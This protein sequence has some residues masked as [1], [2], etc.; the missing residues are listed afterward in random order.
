MHWVDGWPEIG[1]DIDRNGIGEPVARHR[2]P[3]V[4][5]TYPVEVP[6][7]NDEFTSSTLG[8]QWQWEAN[9][10]SA[11]F[12]LDVRKGWLRLYTQAPVGYQN[13]LWND[14]N[15]LGQKIPGPEF[16]VTTRFEY[17]SLSNGEEAGLI[18]LGTDYAFIAIRRIE[19]SFKVIQNVC[20]D[21]DKGKSEQENS[22]VELTKGTIY[23]R[24]ELRRESLCRFSFSADGKQFQ[25]LGNEF[26][27][28]SGKW[29]GAKIGLF[30]SGR[31]DA[32]SVGFVD[33]DWIRFDRLR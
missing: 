8:L 32:R 2:K 14:G 5:R 31:D 13:N 7:T 3:D 24:L 4:V 28:K 1:A 12:S 26:H 15:I 23:L 18:V 19:D 25:Q 20:T 30:A 6:Q 16:S 17:G 10:D 22:R 11:F 9:P 29:V 33:S 27:T 21:A